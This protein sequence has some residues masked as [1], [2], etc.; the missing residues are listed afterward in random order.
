[1]LSTLLRLLPM[2]EKVID[3]RSSLPILKTICIDGGLA[4]VTDLETTL[5]MLQI[6]D[7][8]L[9]LFCD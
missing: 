9:Q 5:V 8:L 4:R 2:A 3:K 6:P 1:M 7:K